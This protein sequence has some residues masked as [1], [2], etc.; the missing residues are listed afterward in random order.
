MNFYRDIGR[1]VNCA[2]QPTPSEGKVKHE[3]VL[4]MHTVS[5]K[6][7]FETDRITSVLPVL[8]CGF[9]S[10]LLISLFLSETETVVGQEEHPASHV[11]NLKRAC[12]LS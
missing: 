7:T 12:P 6:Y 5:G 4:D 3:T 11:P 10:G 1:N 9:H 2:R 8:H